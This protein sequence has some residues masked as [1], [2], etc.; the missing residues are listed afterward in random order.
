MSDFE[1]L[2]SSDKTVIID[3]CL[4]YLVELEYCMTGRKKA[5]IAAD[6]IESKIALVH[7]LL[8]RLWAP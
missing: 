5:G 3:A 1:F 4:S 2:S 6:D 8:D 7:D